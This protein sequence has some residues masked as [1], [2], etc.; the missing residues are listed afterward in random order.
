LAL[1]AA[2]DLIRQQHTVQ[3]IESRKG[4]I[5]G[6]KAIERYCAK[7]ERGRRGGPQAAT[8]T[9]TAYGHDPVPAGA[10]E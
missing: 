8:R 1:N 5:I 4:V 6:R 7:A 10:H 2:C 3:R 9:P